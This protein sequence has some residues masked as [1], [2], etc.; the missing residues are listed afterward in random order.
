MLS[1][2]GFLALYALFAVGVASAVAHGSAGASP[3]TPGAPIAA[4]ASVAANARAVAASAG[5]AVSAPR[6]ERPVERALDAFA[7]VVKRQSDPE[8]LRLAFGAYYA[9]KAAHP[10][11][12]RNP[13]LYFV[14]YGLDNATPRG[15]VF[16]MDALRVVDGPFTVAHGRGSSRGRNGVPTR[17]SNAPGSAASSLGLFLTQETYAF[18][19]HANGRLYHSVGLR[20]RGL[21]GRFNDDARERGVVV[22]GAPYVTARD[23]GRSEGCPAMQPE[24]ARRLIPMIAHGGVVFLYSPRDRTWLRDGPWVHEAAAGEVA[25]ARR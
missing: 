7:G 6:G 17:F 21:S 5:E 1:R 14:D 8:A 3:S 22:H 23:A 10:D 9:F 24:R 25:T 18:S 12:V 15:Y 2:P 13:Y 20:L 19:G 4:V 11:E 16:D